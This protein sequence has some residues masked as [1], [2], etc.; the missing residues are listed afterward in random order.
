MTK[1][2]QTLQKPTQNKGHL[3]VHRPEPTGTD[4]DGKKLHQLYES[5]SINK[6]AI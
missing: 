4:A 2:V 6:R 1:Q 3:Q 5:K